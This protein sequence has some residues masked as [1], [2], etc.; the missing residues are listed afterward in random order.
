[1]KIVYILIFI[2]A[3]ITACTPG[4]EYDIPR[5]DCKYL[6]VNCGAGECI[7]DDD[8]YHCECD[9]DAAWCS[10]I[11]ICVP[12]CTD[13]KVC[14]DFAESTIWISFEFCNKELGHCYDSKD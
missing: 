8:Y 13:D 5:D 11:G 1:M 2:L 10:D 9:E 3:L 12:V 4:I 7:E 6:D 14:E